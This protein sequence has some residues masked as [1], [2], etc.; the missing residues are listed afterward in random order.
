[1]N[2]AELFVSLGVKGS[3]K[4]MGA[5]TGMRQGLKDT[6][7]TAWETKVAL[8]GAMY[9]LERLFAASGQTG[10]SLTNFNAL[11]G[12]SAQTLQ[13]YQYAARQAGVSNQEV[14]GTFKALQATM[15]KTLMGEGAPKGMARVA[16]LTGSMTTQDV[17]R[18]A[19]QP[20]LLIQK[21]QEYA[22]KETN[23]G[24]RNEVLKSFGVGDSM[25]AAL[26]RKAFRPE[27][28]N[29]APAYSDKEV[30]ALDSANIGWSNLGNKIEMAIGHLNAAHG[31]D[32]VKDFSKI[33]DQVIKLAGAFEKLSEK[34][35]LF[36]WLGKVFEGWTYIFVALTAAI[37]KMS[38]TSPPELGA[39]GKPQ[40]KLSDAGKV[41]KD[42][43]A[44]DR[45]TAALF[46]GMSPQG[47][48]LAGAIAEAVETNMLPRLTQGGL[49]GKGKAMPGVTPTPAPAKAVTAASA[50]VGGAAGGQMS[51]LGA[52]TPDMLKRMTETAPGRPG[53][54]AIVRLVV[55]PSPLMPAP[56]RAAPPSVKPTAAQSGATHNVEVKQNLNFTHDGKD[57]KKT[58]DSVK[59]AVQEAYRQTSAQG[60]G[61]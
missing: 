6:A 39:D 44:F 26:N 13:Q 48:G 31:G 16:A 25:I 46:E 12:V 7:S 40:K 17:D 10:T 59:K 43:S 21:L 32:L 9:A 1:M 56:E 28:L 18:F 37:E 23:A 58:A 41:D 49:W 4:T 50:P 42:Q 27:V 54:P 52:L 47:S 57:A 35:E 24:L 15:T 60:Q 29:R 61:S 11:L 34:A 55:P 22:Q 38:D 53:S 45:F 3:E 19:K 51:I 36:K 2:L 20:Q 33:T 30:K 5:I 14:E 8:V